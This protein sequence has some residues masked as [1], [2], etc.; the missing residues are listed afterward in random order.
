MKKSKKENHLLQKTV[1]ELNI[2]RNNYLKLILE[3]KGFKEIKLGDEK[4][5][6]NKSNG[7]LIIVVAMVI[8]KLAIPNPMVIVLLLVAGVFV[9]TMHNMYT[10]FKEEEAKK[11]NPVRAHENAC[12]SL[13]LDNHYPKIKLIEKWLYTG[14]RLKK[15]FFI[16]KS[17]LAI[18]SY[19]G[20]N[21]KG[22]MFNISKLVSSSDDENLVKKRFGLILSLQS[23]NFSVKN[24]LIQNKS[25]RGLNNIPENIPKVQFEGAGAKLLNK[26]DVFSRDEEEAS[27]LLT[28]S[29]LKPLVD[30]AKDFKS[31]IKWTDEIIWSFTKNEIS[32]LVLSKHSFFELPSSREMFERKDIRKF[33]EEMQEALDVIARIDQQ[34]TKIPIDLKQELLDKK[35][36]PVKEDKDNS[37]YDHLID[38]N[39][40]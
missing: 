29:F 13:I 27:Q 21:K 31:S 16:R 6:N 17:F 2:I 14:F 5:K 22:A 33:T 34:L 15:S 7:F 39:S 12:K 10:S 30:L 19:K 40:N 26:Y 9:M 32:L 38:H 24:I 36:A 1:S 35:N 28:T 3:D 37:P 23:D 18:S 8:Y 11:N 4:S 20:T 25:L